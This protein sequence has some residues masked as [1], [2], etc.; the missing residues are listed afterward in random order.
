MPQAETIAIEEGFYI[1][2]RGTQPEEAPH[3]LKHGEMLA[4]LDPYGDIRQTGAGKQGLYC[5]D[6]RFLSRFL[7]LIQGIGRPL[8]LS[9]TLQ[10]DNVLLSANL[11][12]PD[13]SQN[14]RVVVPRG[15]LHI[16]RAIFLWNGACYERVVVRNYGRTPLAIT[17]RFEFSADF[18]DMFE[19]RGMKRERRGVMFA[20]RHQPGSVAMSYR[21]LDGAIRR[22]RITCTP[23]PVPVSPEAWHLPITVPRK[24]EVEI[25]L[26]TV[27]EDLPA[28]G[29]PHAGHVNGAPVHRRIHRAVLSR[30]RAAYPSAYR[31]AEADTRQTLQQYA[32]VSSSNAQFTAWWDR[33]LADLAMMTTSTA[34]GPYPY[35]GVPWFDTPFGRD[36]ILAA[37]ACL[38]AN[39]ELARGVLS[40]LAATQATRLIP[41]QDAE[42]GKIL[43]ETRRG[44]M[45]ALKEVPFGRYYGSVDSTPLF[46]VLAAAHYRRSGDLEF[47]K[48]LWPHVERALRWIDDYGDQ[49]NDGFIEY[50][51]ATPSGLVNQGWKDSHDSVFHAD[52]RLADGPIALCEVQAYVYA[53]KR[54]AAELAAALRRRQRAVGL[55]REARLLQRRF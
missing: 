10:K 31:R 47:V 42:P 12:N 52:G 48:Q 55:L 15:A 36:G 6:T 53:A 38:W 20:P 26:T 7:L 40:F 16:F 43:H 35:A 4:I 22:T 9:S 37:L 8:F 50:Y 2:A 28:N 51:R 13:L 24:D 41:D 3:V 25:L 17:L 11:T 19:V 32:Q 18:A 14:G 45:A 49:D 44:E 23:A 29:K 5:R 34:Y 30:A 39:P 46:V 33:S 1:V 21:G 54:G 27:C